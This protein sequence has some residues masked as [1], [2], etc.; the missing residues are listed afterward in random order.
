M[1]VMDKNVEVAT[2][3]VKADSPDW[4]DLLEQAVNEP[5]RLA[6]AHK[7]FHQYSLA[8]RWL[9]SVQ[10]HAQGLPLQPINTFKGWLGL[11]R[12][13]QKGQKASIAL[14]MPVPVKSKKKDDEGDD[15]RKIVFTKFMLRR[16]WFALSQTDGAEFKA[17]DVQRGEWKL[18]AALEFL[19]VPEVSFEFSSIGDTE[20][21]GWA[22]AKSIAVSPL[23]PHQEL[24]R[25][26]EL[27]RVMLGHTAAEP[28]K[29]VPDT[30]EMRDV[31]AE[32][33]AYLCA[34]TLGF[35]GLDESRARLQGY[36]AG[37]TRMRIPDRLA[38][39]AFSAADKILNAGYC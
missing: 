11:E 21:M 24:A 32:A 39:R 5:G 10:L 8:N 3:E 2:P 26:R 19:E 35:S 9:A 13:V 25:L 14:I 6:E 18:S 34:A 20:R 29:A 7:F 33:A 17:E 27:S 16:Y 38:H 15:E 30:P 23:A 28:A 37:G 31:E 12:P 1:E 22:G 4:Y 36:L